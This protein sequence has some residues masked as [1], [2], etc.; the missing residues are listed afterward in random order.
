MAVNPRGRNVKHRE[1]QSSLP[2]MLRYLGI[3]FGAAALIATLFTAWTPA[4]LNPGEL[5]E[6]LLA[7]A[8]GSQSIN[9]DEVPAAG[10]AEVEQLK[11][12]LVVGHS[13]PN[14]QT[15][16]VDPGAVCPDGLT[17]LEI[18]QNVGTIAAASLRA[19]GF[20]VQL[21]EEFDPELVSFSALALVSIHADACGFINDEATGYKIT[22]AIDTAVPDRSQRLVSCLVDR[23]G[24]ATGLD[25]HPASIT[26][27]MTEYH[28]FYE[29]HSQTPAAIIETGFLYLDRD[30][31]SENPERV[32]QGIVEGI[33]CYANNEPVSTSGEVSP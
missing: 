1:N 28:T 33:L 23:Y 7:V 14:P 27:D 8:T 11:V 16:F 32:A 29:I 26:R 5:V 21:L 6:Q 18:N 22:A 25:F 15:G 24:R 3:T 13:G 17:E 2:Q 19:A 12:G 20:E 9:A 10:V 31:L 30:F 4:S